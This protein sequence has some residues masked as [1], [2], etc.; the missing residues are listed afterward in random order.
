MTLDQ[1]LAR[2]KLVFSDWRYPAALAAALLATSVAISQ[3]FAVRLLGRL[4][5]RSTAEERRAIAAECVDRL[6]AR[7]DR[8]IVDL[9]DVSDADPA[10]D[11]SRSEA[12]IRLDLRGATADAAVSACYED[13][14]E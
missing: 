8:G 2:M 7:F 9:L 12:E 11:P 13:V 6:E 3:V 14:T 1:R 4:D 10:N 5:E